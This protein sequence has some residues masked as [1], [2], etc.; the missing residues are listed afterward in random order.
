MTSLLPTA[1]YRLQF[2]R[3]FTFR[4]A[5][6]LVPYLASLGISHVYSSPYFRARPDSMHGYDIIDHNSLNPEIGSPEDYDSFVAA[7]HQHGMG[8]ILD[9]V[10]NHMG[11]MGS[12]N[13][14]WLDVLE[15]GEASEFADFFDIDWQP[16]K[17]ELRDK[18]LVPI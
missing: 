10:P 1:T 18:V 13:A 16:I 6:A 8:Q 2:N 9:V 4:D 15:N 11:V 12:D 7:L 14:W 17:E 5:N 3:G